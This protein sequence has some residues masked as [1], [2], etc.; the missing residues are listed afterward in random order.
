M[1]ATAGTEQIV[2]SA[3]EVEIGYAAATRTDH[4]Q[5]S[6]STRLGWTSS[7][8][9]V[10]RAPFSRRRGGDTRRFSWRRGLLRHQWLSDHVTSSGRAR[11]IRLH[12]GA[13]I[14]EASG[15]AAAAGALWLVGLCRRGRVAVLPQHP[16]GSAQ[17][18]SG[19]SHLLEQLVS[20]R[21]PPLL[22]RRH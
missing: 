1:D 3:T 18:A 20:D 12:L 9:R 4:F 17:P 11:P 2:P 13:P 16:G 22:L 19:G 10:G 14:L 21:R 6:V 7:R 8:G 15:P 5:Y